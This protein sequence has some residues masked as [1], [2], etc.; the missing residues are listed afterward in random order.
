MS[1]QSVR[2]RFLRTV[3]AGT[4]GLGLGKRGCATFHFEVHA[5]SVP[6]RARHRL[7]SKSRLPVSCAVKSQR[8]DN[9]ARDCQ[10]VDPQRCA[11]DEHISSSCDWRLSDFF[12]GLRVSPQLLLTRR[13]LRENDAAEVLRRV[14]GG[15]FGF[16]G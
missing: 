16:A 15:A 13:G 3:A 2:R 14:E 4:V 7:R 8:L 10:P 6:G 9:P 1:Q 12:N 11:L 5:E